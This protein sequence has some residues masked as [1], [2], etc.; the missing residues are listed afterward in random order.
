[1]N[2]TFP[3]KAGNL[4]GHFLVP[5]T[6]DGVPHC[7]A[8]VVLHDY[9]GVDECTLAAAHRLCAGGYTVAV[10][11]LFATLELPKEAAT[12]TAWLDFTAALC[13]NELIAGLRATVDFLAGRPEVQPGALGIVGWGWGG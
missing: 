1:M 5:E 9:Y 10:P 6:R 8:L 3:S 13:D 2:A 11:D 12:E 7:P 4:T